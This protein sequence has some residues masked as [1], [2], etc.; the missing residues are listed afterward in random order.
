MGMG[1]I[2]NIFRLLINYIWYNLEPGDI[3]IFSKCPLYAAHG[4]CCYR[5]YCSRSS[6][7][8]SCDCL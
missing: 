8:F 1:M 6:S 4:A 3:T 7:L 5:G 2:P